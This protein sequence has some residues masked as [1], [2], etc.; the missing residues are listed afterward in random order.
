MNSHQCANMHETALRAK[1]MRELVDT[2]VSDIKKLPQKKKIKTAV[3]N[4]GIMGDV[5]EIFQDKCRQSASGVGGGSASYSAS[6]NETEFRRMKTPLQKPDAF[7]N[8]TNFVEVNRR[9][10]SKSKFDSKDSTKRK[11]RLKKQET[12]KS[13]GHLNTRS[14]APLDIKVP[15][16]KNERV[17][18][19]LEAASI[20]ARIHSPSPIIEKWIKSKKVPCGRTNLY[21]LRT[22]YLNNKLIR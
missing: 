16:P 9:A 15:P 18:S 2:V 19:P 20:L 6:R 7:K 10:N 21:E 1:D 22:K 12:V 8:L 3:C 5:L 14:K 17:Y 13:T 4:L 11:K